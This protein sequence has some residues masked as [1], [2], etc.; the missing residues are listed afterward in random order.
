MQLCRLLARVYDLFALQ[1]LALVGLYSAG[2]PVAYK[3]SRASD[4]FPF[5]ESQRL[6]RTAFVE[7]PIQRALAFPFVFLLPAAQR[8]DADR[9][10]DRPLPPA[11]L[12]DAGSQH[13]HQPQEPGRDAYGAGR[14]RRYTRGEHPKHG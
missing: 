10:H 3:E 12:A 2:L 11:L 5:A 1:H 4:R 9:E 6:G 8:R 7:L 14:Y 13:L